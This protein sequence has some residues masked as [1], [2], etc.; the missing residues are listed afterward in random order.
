[1]ARPSK[2]NEGLAKAITDALKAGSTRMAAA[3]YVGVNYETFRRWMN[4]N[5]D[6][7]ALVTRAESEA[8]V[9]FTST[10]AKAARGTSTVPGDWRAAESWLKRRRRG[11]WGDSIDIRKL[12]DETIIRLFALEAGDGETRVITS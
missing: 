8:E 1:M 2:Y 3:E 5:I 6:F 4:D 7:Y 10:L 11:E 9:M 12:D